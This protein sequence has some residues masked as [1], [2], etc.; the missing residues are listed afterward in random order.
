M[1][2]S[3]KQEDI[4]AILVEENKITK[5]QYEEFKKKA[6]DLGSPIADVIRS[7]DTVSADVFY[8]AYAKSKGT[9][10]VGLVG[11]KIDYGVLE[12]IP[13]KLAR[14]YRMVAIAIDM[15]K[16]V[17]RV[18]MH[19]PWDTKAREAIDHISRA[20]D[21][22]PEYLL[23]TDEGLD[24]VLKQYGDISKEVG[25]A[26]QSAKERFNVEG[27]EGSEK[28]GKVKSKE[29]IQEVVKHAPVAKMVSVILR[30][31][32]EGKAS[33]IHIE[34][35]QNV[36]RV[37]YRI[38][39]TL[40]TS[41][42][43]PIY[44][45]DAVVARVKVM[46]N[47]KI[48]ETRIPQDGRI[49]MELQ[50]RDVEFR[51]STLPLQGHEKVVMRV[52]DTGGSAPKLPDLGYI[53]R[54][55][56]TIKRNIVKPNGMLLITGPTGSGKSMTL[57]SCLNIVNSE[58][59]NIS[60]LEDPVEYR[61]H[62]TNQSQMHPEVGFTFAMGLR[63]LLRQDPNIIMVGEIRDFET[64]ELAVHAAMTGHLVFSTLH[65][66]SA[67]GAV[68][69]I[70]D[71]KV[72]PFLLSSTLNVVIAQRLVK[73]ICKDCKEA[74]QLDATV[75]AELVRE[76]RAV[77]P[78]ILQEYGD[79]DLENPA[80]YHGRGC[81]KCG[82]IGFKGRTAIA[83]VIENTKEMR[84]AINNKMKPEDLKKALEMQ[85]FITMKQDG[86]IKSFLGWTTPEQVLAVT[87]E[88]I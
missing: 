79:I 6:S 44:I 36:S 19:D 77:P 20:R 47:L 5:E 55:L 37:R 82:Q 54:N 88:D 29:S 66:N 73:K 3:P 13:E 69:R 33:D 14:N 2:I 53:G 63:A 72:E 42:T 70:L 62:G 22:H 39:G 9:E 58:D 51:V 60:T 8:S 68:P 24:F 80:F 41:I 31:A 83:E 71:M 56:E 1:V 27:E 65:T 11:R 74:V 30:H 76:V 85:R 78:E 32:V 52:L 16:R 46:S 28:K 50:D 48:D 7:A 59:V 49:R 81:A 43:L 17:L 38:D 57:F 61:L 64:A 40:R 75:V 23:T 4:G 84:Y 35:M 15:Q 18:A 21:L 25:E 86:I 87:K 12:V 10:F 34:P 45:H 67:I 26:L